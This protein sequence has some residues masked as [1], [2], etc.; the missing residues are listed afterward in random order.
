MDVLKEYSRS[1]SQR[2]STP[3]NVNHS[4]NSPDKQVDVLDP[5][6]R[7]VNFMLGVVGSG[8][9]HGNQEHSTR[10]E[11]EYHNTSS[12]DHTY[13]ISSARGV[14]SQCF[15]ASRSDVQAPLGEL[16][17]RTRTDSHNGYSRISSVDTDDQ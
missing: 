6:Y 17:R 4:N 1:K 3:F 7:L 2:V 10:Q 12:S 15:P 11:R 14:N 5:L 9:L 8:K 13:C 16:F